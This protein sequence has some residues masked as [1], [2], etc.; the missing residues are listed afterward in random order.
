MNRKFFDELEK[1]LSQFSLIGKRLSGLI[2]SAN[3]FNYKIQIPEMYYSLHIN[4]A[5]W[6]KAIVISSEVFESIKTLSNWSDN[7]SKQLESMTASLSLI[8]KRIAADFATIN[9]SALKLSALG[10]FENLE[11]LLDYHEDSANAFKAAGWVIAPSMNRQIREKVVVLYHQN[12]TRYI[13]RVILGYYHK[14]NFE[15]LKCAVAAW[16]SNPLFSS[17]MHIFRDALSAHC[18]GTY[19]LSVPALLPQIEGVL[20]EYV[21]INNLEAK[22]GSIQKVYKAVIG[23]MDE[24]PLPSW[25]IANTLLYQL[26]TITFTFTD[27]ETEFRKAANNRKA[28]RHTVL[29]GISINYDKPILSLKAFVLLDALSSLLELNE[30]KTV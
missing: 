4:M 13:S 21:K 26:Q 19:T 17:R 28:T 23:D 5:E 7:Y 6:A 27:F 15:K 2:T 10:I 1:N 16:E 11:K 8:G 25:A 3:L 12:K 30:E 29:H 18:K 9:L 14:N 24:Y 22:L 20:N